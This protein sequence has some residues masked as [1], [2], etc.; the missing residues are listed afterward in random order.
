MKRILNGILILIISS[1]VA[2][3]LIFA[4][5]HFAIRDSSN[6]IR[7]I[8]S[9][10]IF[11]DTSEY[12]SDEVIDSLTTGL[13]SQLSISGGG[14]LNIDPLTSQL[15][16]V[17]KNNINEVI[18]AD[19]LK[20]LTYK[21]IENFVTF[22]ND[23]E[24]DLILFFPASD[25]ETQLVSSVPKL[26]IEL[27]KVIGNFPTCSPENEN[28]VLLGLSSGQDTTIDCLPDDSKKD[29][30]GE[31]GIDKLINI[32]KVLDESREF[33]TLKT[34]GDEIDAREMIDLIATNQFNREIAFQALTTVKDFT[35]SFPYM[36]MNLLVITAA[37][38]GICFIVNKNDLKSAY[39]GL[40][41]TLFIQTLLT[42]G[43]IALVR[44]TY[45][46]L[47]NSEMFGN[48]PFFVTSY[49]IFVYPYLILNIL[50]LIDTGVGYFLMR[51]LEKNSNSKP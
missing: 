44:I 14:N 32:E 21:N 4:G 40:S 12:I 20:D 11:N 41:L 30:L 5:I 28:N 43:V 6:Y 3:I 26:G 49:D 15:V 25:I 13:E 34:L 2:M 33:Q 31:N 9:S 35:L 46:S 18:S 42:V 22:L 27:K 29:L 37:A 51:H 47:S 36:V 23:P 38:I 8:E 24:I 17:I 48:N 10:G 19:I 16:P 50:V 7:S 39:K 45:G 1:L